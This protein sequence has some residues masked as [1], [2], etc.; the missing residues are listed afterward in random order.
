M[1]IVEVCP[2]EETDG[3]SLASQLIEGEGIE[4]PAS[5]DLARAVSE[6]TGH[7]PYYIHWL[8]AQMS[9]SN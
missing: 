3:M 6:A 5:A 8:V 4:L 7:I 2:L 1:Q 9:G